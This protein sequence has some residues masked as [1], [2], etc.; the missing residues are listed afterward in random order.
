MDGFFNL[1]NAFS[2]LFIPIFEFIRWVFPIKIYRLHD[3]ELGVIKTFG[4]V[5]KW[6]TSDV[7]PGINFCF[8]FEEIEF[9][10]AKGCYLDLSE[11]TI[12]T[13]DNKI[14]I[15]NGAIQYSIINIQKA[16]LETDSIEELLGG[17][18]MNIIR[19][20]SS[21]QKLCDLCDSEKLTNELNKKGGKKLVF[22]GARIDKVMITD[23]R[24][25]D[26]TYLSDRLDDIVKN[27]TVSLNIKKDRN[28]EN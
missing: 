24:P 4:K 9:V 21:Q 16:I 13:S 28:D 12:Y 27:I 25:Y 11:Q 17:F 23:L 7:T 15:I 2:E 5:R 20:W 6:R 14:V 10:Q 1:I 26:V 22:N 8:I 19:E 3:G 18:C